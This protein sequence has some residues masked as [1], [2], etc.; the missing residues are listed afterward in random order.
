MKQQ[1]HAGTLHQSWYNDFVTSEQV[2]T[3]VQDGTTKLQVMDR[4]YFFTLVTVATDC[5]SEK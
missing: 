1:C 5:W 4:N 2:A 3:V